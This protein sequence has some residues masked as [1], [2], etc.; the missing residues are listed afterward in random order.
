MLCW[1]VNG[2]ARRNN[3]DILF[4]H[5]P[6]VIWRVTGL[7]NYPEALFV[8]RKVLIVFPLS[9]HPRIFHTALEMCF[10]LCL[11]RPFP[12][13]S[14]DLFYTSVHDAFCCYN[15]SRCK[16]GGWA[17]GKWVSSPSCGPKLRAYMVSL[18]RE[19]QAKFAAHPCHFCVLCLPFLQESPHND[20]QPWHTAERTAGHNHSQSCYVL[21]WALL[22]LTSSPWPVLSRSR[23]LQATTLLSVTADETSM[24]HISG[25]Q[26]SCAL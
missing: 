10:S 15:A 11:G 25:W 24:F 14:R 3:L 21:T 4:I 16:A 17:Q 8:S 2:I 26:A 20:A 1:E 9:C 12:L 23:R 6:Q 19:S 5:P 13:T 22:Y 18:L 7:C